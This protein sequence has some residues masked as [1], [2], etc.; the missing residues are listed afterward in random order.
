MQNCSLCNFTFPNKIYGWLKVLI[1][2]QDKTLK[3]KLFDV[4]WYALNSCYL[5]IKI[6]TFY[7][8]TQGSKEILMFENYLSI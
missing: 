3:S 7:S 1:L 2:V 5:N 6:P 8:Y 4:E